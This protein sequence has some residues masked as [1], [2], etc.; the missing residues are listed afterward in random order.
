MPNGHQNLENL[1]RLQNSWDRRGERRGMGVSGG[2]F[3]RIQKFCSDVSDCEISQ[4]TQTDPR[5]PRVHCFRRG[6]IDRVLSRVVTSAVGSVVTPRAAQGL[7]AGPT[8]PPARASDRTTV[9]PRRASRPILE[10]TTA[11]HAT[12]PVASVRNRSSKRRFWKVCRRR[13]P[14]RH[15][16]IA[17]L[18]TVGHRWPVIAGQH[19]PRAGSGA[20]HATWPRPAYSLRSISSC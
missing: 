7:T 11:T 13:P 8:T 18:A 4:P 5:D 12:R 16:G 9:A 15:T 17:P 1:V 20:G 3:G 19:R 2:Q 6:T 10:A 14:T